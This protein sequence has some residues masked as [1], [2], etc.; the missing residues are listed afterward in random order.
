MQ[1]IL[2]GF[3]N[4][5][6]YKDYNPRSFFMRLYY[7]S[8]EDPYQ[9]HITTL[10]DTVGQ[11]SERQ[12]T[13]RDAIMVE[14]ELANMWRTLRSGYKPGSKIANMVLPP[15][16]MNLFTYND[17]LFIL[18]YFKDSLLCYSPEGQFARSV[19]INFHKVELLRGIDYKELEFVTDPITSKVYTTERKIAGWVLHPFNTETGKLLPEILLP[20]FAGM[21]EIR[22]Y[23]DAIYFLYHEKLFPYFTRLYRY[24]L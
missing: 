5:L 7:L 6:V 10:L 20:D 15:V 21:T 8:E 13:K 12:D 24:Q 22:A 16:L 23:N 3:N 1:G 11:M 4:K 14:P 17:S 2:C 19:S 18:N 9:H